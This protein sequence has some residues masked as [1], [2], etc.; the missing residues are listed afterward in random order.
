MLSPRRMPILL[1]RVRSAR[2]D[3]DQ[4]IDKFAPVG[5]L[6]DFTFRLA[7]PNMARSIQPQGGLIPRSRSLVFVRET[8][9]AALVKP[10][11]EG[12]VIEE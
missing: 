12:W 10:C 7:N 1:A 9:A 6:A 5:G 2:A 3:G 11:C 4:Y 8:P